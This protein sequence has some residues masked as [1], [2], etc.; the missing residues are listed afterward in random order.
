MRDAR[1]RSKIQRDCNDGV[2][3]VGTKFGGGDGEG[4]VLG[5]L[6]FHRQIPRDGRKLICLALP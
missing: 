6:F 4:E 3:S 5:S 1:S 2:P